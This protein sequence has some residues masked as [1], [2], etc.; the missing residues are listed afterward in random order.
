LRSFYSLFSIYIINWFNKLTKK[1]TRVSAT[2]YTMLSSIEQIWIQTT[3]NP[4]YFIVQS[5]YDRYWF[6]FDFFAASQVV[7]W[8]L[9]NIKSPQWKIFFYFWATLLFLLRQPKTTYWLPVK[10]NYLMSRQCVRPSGQICSTGTFC[11]YLWSKGHILLSNTFKNPYFCL[12]VLINLCTIEIFNNA[13]K[14]IE[15]LNAWPR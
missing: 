4:Y 9:W 1:E 5:L 13:I 6:T 7:Y 15:K 3:N 14:I 2:W 12:L 11:P 8:N 10:K